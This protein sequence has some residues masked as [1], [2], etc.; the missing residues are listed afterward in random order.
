MHCCTATPAYYRPASCGS[1]A[2]SSVATPSISLIQQV[3][4]SDEASPITARQ[5]WRGSWGGAHRRSSPS[6]GIVMEI[7]LYTGTI[8]CALDW[9]GGS[10]MLHIRDLEE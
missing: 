6:W 5:T 7:T 10:H 9:K 8:W 2:T 4:G 1:A 3:R